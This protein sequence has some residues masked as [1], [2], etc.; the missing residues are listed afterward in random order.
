M[1][2]VFEDTDDAAADI[3]DAGAEEI[4]ADAASL[5]SRDPPAAV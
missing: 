5:H 1:T 3:D 4:A 2:V